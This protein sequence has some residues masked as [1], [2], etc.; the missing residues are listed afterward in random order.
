MFEVN[1]WIFLD[2][3]AALL[4]VYCWS[5]RDIGVCLWCMS[6]TDVAVTFV[7]WLQFVQCVVKLGMSV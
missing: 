2:H 7:S 6:P 3:I 1:V 5:E 4:L